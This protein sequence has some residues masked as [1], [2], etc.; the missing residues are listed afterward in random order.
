[1]SEAQWIAIES[2]VMSVGSAAFMAGMVILVLKY[3]VQIG[4]AV[5]NIISR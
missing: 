5:W 1:M 2:G 4:R 3:K